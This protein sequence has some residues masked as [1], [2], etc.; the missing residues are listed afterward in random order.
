MIYFSFKF[1][2]NEVLQI[3]TLINL[4]LAK[5]LSFSNKSLDLRNTCKCL[6]NV[7]NIMIKTT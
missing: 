4:Q 5:I 7:K 3:K 6:K 2:Y 1:K